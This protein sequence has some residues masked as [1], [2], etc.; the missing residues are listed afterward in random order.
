M[1]IASTNTYC[2]FLVYF[3]VVKA[4]LSDTATTSAPHTPTSTL[5]EGKYWWINPLKCI[6]SSS[7]F[8]QLGAA[9]SFIPKK[10]PL[11]Q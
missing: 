5:S 2:V 1:D 10:M 4:E 3:Y 8:Y 11:V 7:S 6:K 9:G